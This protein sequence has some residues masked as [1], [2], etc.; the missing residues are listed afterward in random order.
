[1]FSPIIVTFP[2]IV[3]Q[4]RP[5]T[6][7]F[8]VDFLNVAGVRLAWGVR[9]DAQPSSLQVGAKA[10]Y[11]VDS[12][13]GSQEK[14]PLRIV[15]RFR[16]RRQLFR[17]SIL[18]VFFLVSILSHIPRSD[19]AS[20]VSDK[21]LPEGEGLA[22]DLT[23][24]DADVLKAVHNVLEDDIIHGTNMYEK[25]VGLDQATAE[26]KSAYFGDWKGEGHVF[27]KVRRDAVAPRHFK[28]SADIG[29]VTVRYVVQSVAPN[30]THLAINAVFVEDGSKHV[31]ASDTT[32]ETSE[33]AEIQ[34][35]LV[36]IQREEQ[37]TAEILQKRKLSDQAASIAKERKVEAVRVQSADTSLNG[38][39]Q[40]ADQLQHEME[41]R[42]VNPST[43]LKAAPFHAAS[44]VGTVTAGTDV[45][46]EIVTDYWYGVETPDGH[47][48]WI[49]RDQ[50]APLP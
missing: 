45:L 46:V 25:E 22:I 19:A 23:A 32:V 20:M 42:I 50:V 12:L 47:R 24:S 35:Q 13:E 9:H 26:T 33:F 3:T 10:R 34:A 21:N 6:S 4:N 48:G 29:I 28:N 40:R 41:V 38:L 8:E 39:Q 5:L 14:Q 2:H 43:Q 31:H 7:N 1:M 36:S 17:V 11:W 30:R 44:S 18:P 15:G 49:Q 16:K 37:Q 27:Y